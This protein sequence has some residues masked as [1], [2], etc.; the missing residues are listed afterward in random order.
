MKKHIHYLFLLALISSCA[1]KEA[2]FV[3]GKQYQKNKDY[4]SLVQAVE[5]MPSAITTQQVKKILGEPI[6][7]GFDYRYLVDS[8]GVNNCTIG[9]VFNIDLQGK[10]THRWVDEI[11]E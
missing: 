10:I 4:K 5:L 6:D 9:A 3:Y 7:N 8:T 1:P 2:V 11:C